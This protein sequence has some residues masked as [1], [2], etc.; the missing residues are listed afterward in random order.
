MGG[1]SAERKALTE[2]YTIDALEA[3]RRAKMTAEA[4]THPGE[5]QAPVRADTPA[6]VPAQPSRRD[7]SVRR[8]VSPAVGQLSRLAE[9]LN[10]VV[11]RSDP[12]L[13]DPYD[14]LRNLG[15]EHGEVRC[16]ECGRGGTREEEG[17]T[18][19]LCGDD[20]LHT[21]CRNCYEREFGNLASRLPEPIG[22]TGSSPAV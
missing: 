6:A 12:A 15:G 9:Q 11:Y 22:F 3:E 7:S 4:P 17:W 8:W 5:D 20:Q 18:L 19:Q 21:F 1:L 10:H 2:R 16:A 14:R 13:P